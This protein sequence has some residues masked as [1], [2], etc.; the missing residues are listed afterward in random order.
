MSGQSCSG[1]LTIRACYSNDGYGSCT[2]LGEKHINH[3]LGNISCQSNRW[4]NMHTET[5]CCIYFQYA[6][7][8]FGNRGTKIHSH[9]IDTAN[10]ETDDTCNTLAHEN[11]CR[12]H[13]VGYIGAGA[14]GAEVGCWLQQYQFIFCWHSFQRIALFIQHFLCE[15]INRYL[16]QYFFMSI[17]ATGIS[18][19]FVQQILNAVFSVTHNRGRCAQCG[20]NKFIIDNENSEIKS[21]DVFLHDHRSAIL[22]CCFQGF[23]RLLPGGNI[24]SIALAMIAIDGFDHDRI[25]NA[26]YRGLQTFF[27]SYYVSFR[28]RYFC[29]T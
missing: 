17:A 6:T 18:I 2:S 5:R 29:S 23:Y 8:I 16:R 20:T 13:F 3:R 14:T 9:D 10:V 19:R 1:C 15:L 24:G 22:L 26:V 25:S 12:M 21:G 4:F 11:I 28:H 7:T 27:G